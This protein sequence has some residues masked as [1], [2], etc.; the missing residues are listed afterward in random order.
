M[1]EKTTGRVLVG[2]ECEQQAYKVF[3][4][5]EDG[6]MAECGGQVRWNRSSVG[7]ALLS[8]IT[9]TP[10][11]FFPSY[12]PSSQRPPWCASRLGYRMPPCHL[13]SHLS[14]KAYGGG[15]LHAPSA[16]KEGMFAAQLEVE[17]Q[18]WFSGEGQRIEQRRAENE[19]LPSTM[20]E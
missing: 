1:E 14:R 2:S 12:M 20:P 17:E 4:R 7:L 10:M 5:S 18:A 6:S 19:S 11:L 15:D 3:T 13:D 8:A 9:H 16:T